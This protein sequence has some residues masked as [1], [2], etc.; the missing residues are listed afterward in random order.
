MPV[1]NII[2]IKYLNLKLIFHYIFMLTT[3]H[4]HIEWICQ[5]CFSFSC[6]LFILCEDLVHNFRATR[7]WNYIFLSCVFKSIYLPKVCIRCVCVMDWCRCLLFKYQ[8]VSEFSYSSFET[9]FK[10]N[11][12]FLFCHRVWSSVVSNF[13]Y[14][15]YRCLF[16][17]MSTFH[18][19]KRSTS[20]L[21]LCVRAYYACVCI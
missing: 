15:K 3:E 10:V 4:I 2:S 1:Y 14:P 12:F 6:F 9:Y 8:Y 11:H 18:D 5:Y 20:K 7:V 17:R 16:L 19:M 13:F 21:E